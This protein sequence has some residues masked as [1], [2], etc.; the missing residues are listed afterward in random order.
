MANE[1]FNRG[2]S[3]SVHYAIGFDAAGLVCVVAGPTF[4]A[5]DDTHLATYATL[6]D[7]LG[8]SGRFYGNRPSPL[9]VRYEARRRVGG[10]PAL[11]DPVVWEETITIPTLATIAADVDTV[12]TAVANIEA[13]TDQI[14]TFDFLT[15][16]TRFLTMIE[17]DGGVYRFTTNAVE[18]VVSGGGGLDAAG[19]R[20]AVG[21]AAA[22]LDTQLDAVG[23]AVLTRAVAGDAM[24][25]T[26]AER[27]AV[28]GVVETTL[29]AEHGGGSWETAS[30][31]GTGART[32]T[33]H[34]QDDAAAPIAG[35]FV[36]ATLSIADS[37][38]GLTDAGGDVTFAMD[39]G[40]WAIAITKAGYSSTPESIVVTADATFPVEMI[41]TVV[42]PPADPT[43]SLVYGTLLTSEG[44]PAANVRLDYRLADPPA[45]AGH[46]YDRGVYQTEPSAADGTVSVELLA[47]ARYQ[48][49]RR[50]GPWTN[51]PTDEST[52]LLPAIV[53]ELD[54]D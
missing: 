48:F 34:V 27:T 8:T 30:G 5:W 21:L 24:A 3:G 52:V 14:V 40:T 15:A 51:V 13:V 44:D 25:L 53:T 22:D 41:A 1:Y 26:G 2:L 23:A 33:I 10:A 31:G 28:A 4:E 29:S 18:Q 37:R 32:V 7:E 19:V 35:A 9:I 42:T 39:D 43:R 12:E 6:V 38:T 36:R 47:E 46:G 17:N 45:G 11:S 54:P 20:A 49:R 50:Q 16:G